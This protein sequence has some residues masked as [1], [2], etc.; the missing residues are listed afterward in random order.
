MLALLWPS[1]QHDGR[2]VGHSFRSLRPSK[3]CL[4]Q[5]AFGSYSCRVSDQCSPGGDD[6]AFSFFI[7][8]KYARRAAACSGV[9]VF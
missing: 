9:S 7:R 1:S 4:T 3:Y 5:N 8:A 6:I 2:S